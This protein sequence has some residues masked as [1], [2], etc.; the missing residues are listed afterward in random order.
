[1]FM[2]HSITWPHATSVVAYL[3]VLVTLCI[4]RGLDPE[5]SGHY[6]ACKPEHEWLATAFD[7]LP[8]PSLCF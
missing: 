6:S 4:H 7:R 3:A 1:M 2:F 8:S 5:A